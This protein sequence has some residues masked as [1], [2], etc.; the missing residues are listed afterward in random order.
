MQIEETIELA[1]GPGALWPWISTPERLARWITDVQRFEA[2]PPGDLREGSHLV[3]HL[4]R[5]APIEASVERCEL[6]RA[7]VL[8]ATGLPNDLEVLLTL[9]ID[10]RAGGSALTLRAETQLKGIMMFAEKLIATKAR[11]RLQAWTDALRGLVGR[12]G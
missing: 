4:A 3:A 6:E 7:L 5:G 12:S 11:A 8:R 10:E 2:K 9:S 1:A